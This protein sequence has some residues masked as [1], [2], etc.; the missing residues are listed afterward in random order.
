[1]NKEAKM[2]MRDVVSENKDRKNEKIIEIYN[3]RIEEAG[4]EEKK[5]NTL[6]INAMKK[7]SNLVS[8]KKYNFKPGQTDTKIY[9]ISDLEK[10]LEPFM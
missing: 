9:S 4:I 5:I 10:V 8:S 1:M 2:I 7:A 6:E 3:E